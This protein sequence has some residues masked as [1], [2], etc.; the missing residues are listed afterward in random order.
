MTKKYRSIH[1]TWLYSLTLLLSISAGGGW[2]QG[3][4]AKPIRYVVPSS[5][6]GGNDTMARVFAEALAET[7]GQTVIVE[8]RAGAAGN[9]AAELVAKSASDG[10]TILQLSQAL[11]VNV[12]LYRNL[13]FDLVRDFAA[14]TM[15]SIEPYMVAV[16][17]SLPVKSINDLIL[18]AK[19]RPGALNYPSAGAGT[20]SFL[21]AELFKSMAGV[22]IV[23]VPYKGGGPAL[24]SVVSGE[25]SIYFAPIPPT[26]PHIQQGR[27][28]SIAVA[29]SKRLPAMPDMPTVSESVA[30]YESANW[31]GLL[32]PAKT[33]KSV[34][35]T[36]HQASVMVMSK[37][38]VNK[39]LVDIGY[40]PST[41]QP[42]SFAVYIRDKID[43][44]AKIL[45]QTGAIAN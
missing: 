25:T 9:I 42:D 21:S 6:G 30:G 26:L 4:P 11:V 3:Y 31:Y 44:L 13:P 8:N 2:A 33:P 19:A 39:R 14:V 37:P 35:A 5:P 16:H 12:N 7:L 24:I 27:L 17:P 1:T 20:T 18:L 22:N 23:H 29:T 38:S 43:S 36:L 10:Y 40:V 28:R 41:S 34:I 32:V 15:L 45:Q